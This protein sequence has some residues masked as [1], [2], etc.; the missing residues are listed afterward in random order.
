[1]TGCEKHS[2]AGVAVAVLSGLLTI[3]MILVLLSGCSARRVVI[4]MPDS[5]GHVGAAEVMTDGGKQLLDKSGEMTVVSGRSR[6]PS[7]K[8]TA[9]Q[10]YILTTFAE[11][12][13][14]EPKKSEKFILFFYTGGLNLVD[15]SKAAI[16]DILSAIKRRNAIIISVSGHTD[17]VGSNQLNDRLAY[18]R[19][20]VIRDLLIRNGVNPDRLTVSSHGKGN[21]LVPTRDGFAEP[22]NRRVELIVR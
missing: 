2:T 11:A 3:T 22:R 6:L 18:K 4:L 1:M 12:L 9:D 20:I 7:L 16:P 17:A 19:A 21:P 13:L 14:I 5:D 8:V 15:H 10:E